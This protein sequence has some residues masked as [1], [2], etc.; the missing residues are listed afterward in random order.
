MQTVREVG[1]EVQRKLNMVQL[2]ALF[3]RLDAASPFVL[4]IEFYELHILRKQIV[5][6]LREHGK[7][8]FINQRTHVLF[9]SVRS[10]E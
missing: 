3:L 9:H 2:W 5:K 4:N 10:T 6:D 7:K 1:A 8:L